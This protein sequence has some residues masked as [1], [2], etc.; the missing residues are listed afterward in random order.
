MMGRGQRL[1]S[2][3]R[4]GGWRAGR[5][6]LASPLEASSLER[7][8]A[9][10]ADPLLCFRLALAECG[11]QGARDSRPSEQTRHEGASVSSFWRREKASRNPH[12]CGV[13]GGDSKFRGSFEGGSVFLRES[14][15]RK[16]VLENSCISGFVRISPD[17]HADYEIKHQLFFA[18]SSP[19]S[20][21]PPPESNARI[22]F[23]T[24]FPTP[25]PTL[26]PFSPS[27]ARVLPPFCC[28]SRKMSAMVRIHDRMKKSAPSFAFP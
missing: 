15:A 10:M 13:C 2:S 5:R 20:P 18:P 12:S 22:P 19:R 24:R 21:S 17:L 28:C 26:L 25:T 16:W 14:D 1:R 6:A 11:A 27:L 9:E 8:C 4:R 7:G 23:S 3:A